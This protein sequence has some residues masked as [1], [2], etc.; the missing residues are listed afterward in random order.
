MFKKT[1]WHS[2]KCQ[3]AQHLLQ[4]HHKPISKIQTQ[5]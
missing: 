3:N 2:F 5:F 4:Y 1:A